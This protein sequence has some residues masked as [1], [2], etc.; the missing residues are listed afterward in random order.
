MLLALLNKSTVPISNADNKIF[1][2]LIRPCN[3]PYLQP[4]TIHKQIIS[5]WKWRPVL[6]GYTFYNHIISAM[7]SINCSKRNL[8]INRITGSWNSMIR[9]CQPIHFYYLLR[10]WQSIYIAWYLLDKLVMSFFYTN[11]CPPSLWQCSQ[12]SELPL[13]NMEE[14]IVQDTNKILAQKKSTTFHWIFKHTQCTNLEKITSILSC[15]HRGRSPT[16]V[17]PLSQGRCKGP[18]P[19]YCRKYESVHAWKPYFQ[20][21]DAPTLKKSLSAASV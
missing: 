5:E 16:A 17:L 20:K 21:T 19:L 11:P 6:R 10:I 14:H 13:L 18:P 3:A 2:V 15:A 7:Q 8:W 12:K 1:F 4:A 9:S